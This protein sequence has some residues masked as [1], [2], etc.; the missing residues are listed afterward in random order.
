M[1]PFFH[2]VLGL[3]LSS[4][5]ILGTNSAIFAIPKTHFL[6]IPQIAQAT[7][8]QTLNALKNATYT[9]PDQGSFSLSN[10]SYQKDSVTL[11]LIN[12]IALGD[13]NSD[14]VQDAAAILALQTGG[15]GTFMYL[16]II[17]SQAGTITN[18][19]TIPLGDRVRVQSLNIKN[20]Q[21]RLN[22]LKHKSTDPQCCPTNLVT[23]VYQLNQS[24]TKLAPM[25][26]SESQKQQIYIED[27]PLPL[28]DKIDND[29]TPVQPQ[30]GEIQ[31]KL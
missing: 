25:T 22:I 4:T 6:V 12:P 17:S 3:G 21:V 16:A 27:T 19:D 11:N 2:F 13:I 29:N 7:G 15:S 28:I 14:G 8:D 1:R 24:S 9:I 5:L 31:L 18:L 10:G 26:L 23:E 30:L 20:G